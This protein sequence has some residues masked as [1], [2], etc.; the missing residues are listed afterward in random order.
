MTLEDIEDIAKSLPSSSIGSDSF[1]FK[2]RLNPR[3]R[4]EDLGDNLVDND[5]N[6]YRSFLPGKYAVYIRTW[7]CTH[8]SS[9]SEYMAGLLTQS[10]YRIVESPEH[11]DLLILNSCTVKNP[12]EDHFRN[13]IKQTQ[14]LNKKLVVAGCVPQSDNKSPYLKEVSIIGRYLSLFAI[15]C[16]TFVTNL[17]TIAQES[18]RSTRLCT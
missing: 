14:K 6:E 13:E 11:A 12:A 16:C 17:N 5:S 4:K 7:G 15:D 1:N 18:N 9:D 2:I 10:G 3:Y 8:N